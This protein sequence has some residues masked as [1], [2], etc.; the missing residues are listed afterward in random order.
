MSI[1][2]DA[3]SSLI[4]LEIRF[5]SNDL[6]DQRDLIAKR[7]TNLIDLIRSST[8]RDNIQTLKLQEKV[9]INIRS[10]FCCLFILHKYK[11]IGELLVYAEPLNSYNLLLIACFKLELYD[12][13]VE[14][15][16]ENESELAYLLD[17]CKTLLNASIEY[18]ANAN[19]DV[20]SNGITGLFNLISV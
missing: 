5:D 4:N 18:E 16:G 17:E 19:L 15:R 13:L 1:L 11:K 7:C 12:F 6:N 3:H 9:I 14:S 8:E 10:T 2:I 20:L